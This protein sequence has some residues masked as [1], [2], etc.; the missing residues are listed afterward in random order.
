[1]DSRALQVWDQHVACFHKE[2]ALRDPSGSAAS[3]PLV[4]EYL[5]AS[6]K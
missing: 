3:S 6:K 4:L 5:E 1:M 2:H